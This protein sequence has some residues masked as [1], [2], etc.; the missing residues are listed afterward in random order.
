MS[1]LTQLLNQLRT[2]PP[3]TGRMIQ[4][5]GNV[6][7]EA[8]AFDPYVNAI[9]TI[10]SIHAHIHEGI[11]FNISRRIDLTADQ[12]LYFVGSVKENPIHFNRLSYNSNEG[13]IEIRL[14][15]GVTFSDGALTS[16]V[17]KNRLSGNVSTLAVR[18]GATVTDTG[19]QLNLKGLPSPASGGTPARIPQT[20]D[21]SE[22]V[23]MPNTDY[24]IEIKE[25]DSNAKILYVD[26]LWYEPGLLQ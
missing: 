1:K 7:N 23:L 19:T 25:L 14:L 16:G 17:N 10:D 12:T 8:D 11:A 15:E 21:D 2:D 20:S 3:R 26:M 13:G 18:E 6:I 9:I 22:W 4:E 24:A 5:S